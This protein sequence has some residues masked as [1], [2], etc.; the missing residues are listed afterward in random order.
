VFSVILV[1][2][3]VLEEFVSGLWRGESAAKS[4][5]VTEHHLAGIV[6]VAFIM[7]V[8]L[9]PYFAFSELARVIGKDKLKALL[10]SH[11]Q[12]AHKERSTTK[13]QRM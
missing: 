1:V 12:I 5:N 8:A 7:F 4:V 10:L 13:P 3:Y 6:S 2:F 9:L 11:R